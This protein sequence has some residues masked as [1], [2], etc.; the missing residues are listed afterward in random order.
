MQL[1][2]QPCTA[3]V[4]GHTSDKNWPAQMRALSTTILA[5]GH[6]AKCVEALRK[7]RGLKLP[8]TM[9]H[10]LWMIPDS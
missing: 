3:Q 9:I 4:A 5:A 6:I 10:N 8:K 7:G 1:Q 2:I